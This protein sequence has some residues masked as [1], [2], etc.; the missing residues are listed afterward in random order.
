MCPV[1]LG[2]KTELVVREVNQLR[3]ATQNGFKA[4]W[5]TQEKKLEEELDATFGPRCQQLVQKNYS[6][7]VKRTEFIIRET[8]ELGM[9]EQGVE[10]DTR[11]KQVVD[12]ML[13]KISAELPLSVSVF[14]RQ[15]LDEN[16]TALQQQLQTLVCQ[17]EVATFFKSLYLPVFQVPVFRSNCSRLWPRKDLT[18]K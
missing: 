10:Q 5:S 6:A 3:G 17:A 12:E 8:T 2:R 16:A 1:I 9:L 15:P 14:L 18:Q 7:L 11:R 13:Q 4:H